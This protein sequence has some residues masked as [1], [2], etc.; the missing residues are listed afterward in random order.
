M[1]GYGQK[2]SVAIIFQNSFDLG[3]GSAY[4]D[5]GS[6]HF[7]GHVSESFKLNIP[8]MYAE[9]IQGVFDEGDTYEGARTVEGDIETLSKIIPLGALLNTVFNQVS[10]VESGSFFTKTFKP[11]VSDFDEEYCA[12][13]PITAYIDRDVGSADLYP[14]M[15]GNTLELNVSAGAFLTA[16]VGFVGGYHTQQAPVSAS[17]YTGKRQT[18]DVASTSIGGVANG[19]IKELTVKME[20]ALEAQHTNNNSKYPSRI[21]RTGWRTIS[22]EGTLAFDSRDEYQQYLAQSERSMVVHFEGVTEL[23]S[24]YNESLTIKLPSM[25]YEDF[26]VNAGGPGQIDAS[27]SGK[28]KYNVNSATAMEIIHV[29]TF[30]SY[31]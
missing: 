24:G 11:R 16:T 27:F 26:P 7:I 14:N 29:S 23:S 2:S 31:F 28:G 22:V 18:W 30:D 25:R 9:D 1:G 17:Y 15:N 6:A 20:S 4:G 5:V 12:E 8:P 10:N 3:T 19:S 13:H 21:K